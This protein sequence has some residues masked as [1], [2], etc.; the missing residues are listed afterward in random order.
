MMHENRKD[1][2]C[3]L[4]GL[5]SETEVCKPARKVRVSKAIQSCVTR[6]SAIPAWRAV[7]PTEEADQFN[8][9]K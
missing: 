6:H 7:T 8:R 5:F 3:E 4:R 2:S 9:G 1:C